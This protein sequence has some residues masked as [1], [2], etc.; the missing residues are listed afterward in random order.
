MPSPLGHALAGAAAG[1]AAAGLVRG[2]FTTAELWRRG[3]AFGVLGM[4]PDIDLLIGAHRGPSHSLTAALIVGLAVLAVTRQGAL[5][6]ASAASY[7]SHVLLD[8]LGS[9][10]SPPIGVMALWPVTRDYYESNVHL[11]EA[12]SRRY[13]LPEFWTH[14]LRAVGWEVVILLPLA[15]AARRGA[16]RRIVD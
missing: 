6:L 16:K 3:A 14:N 12:V 11:F 15:W 2:P 4:L 9:D 8:W 1:W 5:A 10:T 7:A 13:W